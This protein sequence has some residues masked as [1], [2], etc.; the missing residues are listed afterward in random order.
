MQNSKFK[1]Q[2]S[3][4]YSRF[5]KL[6]GSR[7]FKRLLVFLFSCFLVFLFLCYFLVVKPGLKVYADVK[8]VRHQTKLLKDGFLLQDLTKME[9]DLNGFEEL[10]GQLQQDIR[11][12]SWAKPLPFVGGYYQDAEHVLRAAH[13][14]IA[15]GNILIE[16]VEPFADVLGFKAEGTEASLDAEK[17]IEGLVK[18]MPQIAPRLDD[19]AAEFA[20][21][22]QELST[23]DP[24]RYPRS[25]KGIQV[26]SLLTDAKNSMNGIEE[27]MPDI[28]KLLT[29]LPPA[30]GDPTPKTYLILFQNDKELR[31]T[32]GF[33]TAYALMTVEGGKITSVTS[34]DMYKLDEKIAEKIPPTPVLAQY[35]KVEESF[36]RDSN[37]SP[38][39]YQ[40]CQKFE[41]FLA[42]IPGFTQIDGIIGIDTYL[43]KDVLEVL[44]PVKLV[45]YEE[46]FSSENV[47]YQLE[48]YANLLGQYIV[49]RKDLLGELMDAMMDKAFHAPRDRWKPLFEAG[50]EL[51]GEKHI[52]LYL[53]EPAAQTLAEKY[54]YAGR[55]QDFDGDYLHI[56]DCNFAGAKANLYIQETVEQDITVAADG[57][58]TKTVT[59]DLRN[60]EPAD[61]WLNGTYYD[62]MRIYVPKGS[63]LLDSNSWQEVRVSEDLGKTVFETYIYCYPQNSQTVSVTYELPFNVPQGQAL[64]MLVQKQPGADGH[65][66]IINLDGK[67]I[68]EFSLKKDT[69]LELE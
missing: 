63:K 4:F 66:Y 43:V 19:V 30:L 10:V 17:K 65:N 67:K 6:W 61:G 33:L 16:A 14:G 2:S 18:A 32:G 53:H 41:W 7:K 62:W 46:E 54:N 37:L 11:P 22:R 39:F 38:D 5:K 34:D 52:L 48:L 13:H 56:N 35:L 1:I 27:A 40:S 20:V 36:I 64:Q 59:I 69:V 49:G 8:D 26:R 28:K 12:F 57:T 3:K 68:E 15:A 31:P 29:V 58:V 21:I 25:V 47:V 51:V 44:G 55:L 60:P 23:V 45:G 24:N 50:L 9:R 42:R